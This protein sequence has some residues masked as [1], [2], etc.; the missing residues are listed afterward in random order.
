MEDMEK[1]LQEGMWM[2]LMGGQRVA[3]L[4]D[5][6][7]RKRKNWGKPAIFLCNTLPDMT[8]WDYENTITVLLNNKLF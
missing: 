7:F 6:H 8:D 3:L 1:P 4:R 5:L 2:S